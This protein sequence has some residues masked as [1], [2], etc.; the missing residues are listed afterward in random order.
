M[1]DSTDPVQV[2]HR[3]TSRNCLSVLKPSPAPPLAKPKQS[4]DCGRPGIRNVLG[5]PLIFLHKAI[6]RGLED[7]LDT[8]GPAS[9]VAAQT[10]A[11]FPRVTGAC[12]HARHDLCTDCGCACHPFT[13]KP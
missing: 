11:V 12:Y 2:W 3:S 13:F 7:T 5:G 4:A 10:M 9:P 8:D 6:T 1:I